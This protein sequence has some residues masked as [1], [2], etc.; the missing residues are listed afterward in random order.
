[1][2]RSPE[3]TP[4]EPPKAKSLGPLLMIWR[5]AL[6]YPGRVVVAFLAL[7]TTAAAMLAIPAGFKLVIDEGFTNGGDPDEIARWFRYLGGIVV[8]LALGT[9]TR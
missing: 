7:V 1:M 8:V 3:I 2:S 6:N 5:A 9:A 4:S